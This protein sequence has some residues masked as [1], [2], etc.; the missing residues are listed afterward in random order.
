MSVQPPVSGLSLPRLAPRLPSAHKGDYGRALLIGGSRGMGGA[1]ALAGK[2]T[3]RGGAGLVTLAVPDVCLETIAGFEPCYMTMPL[4]SDGEGRIAAT[5]LDQLVP[6]AG[7]ATCVACGPGLGRSPELVSFVDE[8]YQTLQNPM[9]VDADALNALAARRDG[10]AYPGGERVLTPHLGEFRRLQEQADLKS[11][12]GEEAAEKLALRHHIVLVL[13]GP[14][15]LITDG[16]RSVRNT[17]GNPGMATAGSGDVLTGV[18]TALISQ[19]LSGWDAA[20]LGVHVHGRAGDLAAQQLGQVSLI[21]SDLLDFLAP[22]FGELE[23]S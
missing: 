12:T 19:G 3:L 9:V 22:A 14:Q 11:L 13:K 23:E 10:V 21:A 1:I 17:T 8:L 7:R 2:A 5:N 4:H 6:L 18:I 16:R 15:T 20:R